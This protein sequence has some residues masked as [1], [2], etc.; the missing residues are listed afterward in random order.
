MDAVTYALAKNY[1]NK[2][3]SPFGY[4]LKSALLNYKVALSNVANQMVRVYCIGDSITRGEYSSVEFTKS[5]A[6]QLRTLLQTQYGNTP[7]E[8]WIG[9]YEFSLPSNAQPRWAYP[10]GVSSGWALQPAGGIHRS[11]V[12][13]TVTTTTSPIQVTFTGTSVRLVYAQASNG[14][15]AN[16]TIDGSAPASNPTINCQNAPTN[17]TSSTLYTG[18]SAGSHTLTVTPTGNGLVFIEGIFTNDGATNGIQVNRIGYSGSTAANWTSANVLARWANI[19][20]HLAIL[21]FGANELNTNVSVTTYVSNMTTII[22]SLKSNGASIILIPYGQCDPT[23]WGASN[24]SKW[25]DYV[26][27]MYKL[28]D[29]YNLGIVD[30]FQ[31]FG[32]QPGAYSGQTAYNWAQSQSLFGVPNGANNWSGASGTN[33]VHPGDKGHNFIAQTIYRNLLI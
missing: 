33:P 31:A 5:W 13:T 23:G 17:Y 27:A 6:A 3:N 7:G 2:S 19:P 30:I 18:L 4:N 22:N 14:G 28:S 1:A 32:S 9:G 12:Q 10:G 24:T 20:P 11:F 26:Q 8:G 15:S 25:A 21:A 29:Q 16:I